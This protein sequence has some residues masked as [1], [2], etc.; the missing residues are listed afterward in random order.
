MNVREAEKKSARDVMEHLFVKP[1]TA[2]A[3]IFIR[4]DKHIKQGPDDYFT[5]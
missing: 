4:T 1:V 3:R 2:P 5:L